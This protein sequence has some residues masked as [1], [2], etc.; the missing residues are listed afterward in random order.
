MNKPV[1]PDVLDEKFTSAK[2]FGD[3]CRQWEEDMVFYEEWLREHK[4]EEFEDSMEN[5]EDYIDVEE[6]EEDED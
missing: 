5:L 1:M 4:Q 3:A 6:I 2:M